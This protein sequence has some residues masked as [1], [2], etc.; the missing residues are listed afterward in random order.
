MGFSQERVGVA[1]GGFTHTHTRS[2]RKPWI[3]AKFNL[4]KLVRPFAP[5][6][7]T[8]GGSSHGANLCAEV[9]R[10][11]RTFVVI[12]HQAPVY[13][14]FS[15]EDVAGMHHRLQSAAPS[16]NAAGPE[17]ISTVVSADSSHI[18]LQPLVSQSEKMMIKRERTYLP[19]R[20]DGS[21]ALP[22]R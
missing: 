2:L 11:I 19:A 17:F 4:V 1:G 3:S 14:R 5:A 20:T 10:S 13:I 18:F 7:L 22:A 9:I 21:Q 12:L 15:T 16:L 8:D 6:L